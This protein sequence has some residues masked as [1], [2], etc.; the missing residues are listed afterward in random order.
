MEVLAAQPFLISAKAT[1]KGE[2][3]EIIG[4]D[5]KSGR[6]VFFSQSKAIDQETRGKGLYNGSSR[7]SS[8]HWDLTNGYGIG[9]GFSRIEKAGGSVLVEWTGV[10]YPV[11]GSDN[12]STPY[13]SGGW[14][15]VPGS[16]SGPFAGLSGGGTWTGSVAADGGFNEEWSG[17]MEQ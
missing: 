4:K 11:A 13:C 8:A 7:T 16:G 14:F 12:K 9:T 17:L 6:M 1:H 2:K 15:V 5:E 10:C 3:F